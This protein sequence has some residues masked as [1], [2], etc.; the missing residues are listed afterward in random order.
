MSQ[1]E[2]VT[3]L[4]GCARVSIFAHAIVK[5]AHLHGQHSTLPH[6]PSPSWL[7]AWGISRPCWVVGL[8]PPGMA[9]LCNAPSNRQGNWHPSTNMQCSNAVHAASTGSQQHTQSR[10][11]PVTPPA[12]HSLSSLP[13]P[14]ARTSAHQQYGRL[15]FAAGLFLMSVAKKSGSCSSATP[16]GHSSE[17]S[18]LG[19]VGGSLSLSLPDGADSEVGTHGLG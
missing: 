10:L 12:Q 15:I 18:S 16:T 7:P 11:W 5:S 8:R 9:A 2:P 3:D 17:G 14:A 13:A 1:C 4:A 6:H 19:G